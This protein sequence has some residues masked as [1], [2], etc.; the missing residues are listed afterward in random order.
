[1][2]DKALSILKNPLVGGSSVVFLGTFAAN[3]INYIFNLL[4]GR[5]LS[6]SDYGLLVSLNSLFVLISIFSVSFVNLFT[7]F[8]AKYYSSDNAAGARKLNCIWNSFYFYLCFGSFCNFAFSHS[9]F[10]QLFLKSKITIIS[11]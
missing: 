11:C 10:F 2:R 4:M 9:C 1:M 6:I 5:L 7:K 8:S 3:I